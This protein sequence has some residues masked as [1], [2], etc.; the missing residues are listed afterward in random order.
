M[1]WS[2]LSFV[3]TPILAAGYQCLVLWDGL[4]HGSCVAHT[5]PN[6]WEP[7]SVPQDKL[8]SIVTTVTQASLPPRHPCCCLQSLGV[9]SN[10]ALLTS[11]HIVLASSLSPRWRLHCC[12][13]SIF[14]IAWVYCPRRVSRALLPLHWHGHYC[15]GVIVTVV[16]ASSPSLHWCCAGVCA[17]VVLAVSLS[18]CRLCQ[19]RA[20]LVL[21]KLALSLSLR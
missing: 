13:T 2:F 20:G 10:V 7:V 14:T 16:W 9:F 5:H 15:M 1:V 11:S 3:V 18:C 17:N 12:C 8:A 19:R 6:C 21:L 4:V